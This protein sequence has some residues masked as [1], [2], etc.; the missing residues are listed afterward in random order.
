MHSVM[1]AKNAAKTMSESR[2]E[3]KKGGRKSRRSSSKRGVSHEGSSRSVS[4]EGS[5]RSVPREGSSRSVSR[6]GSSR[7]LSRKSSSRQLAR[8][9][10][11][12]ELKQAV[13]PEEA[14]QLLALLKQEAMKGGPEALVGWVI[15]TP[16][17]GEQE[18]PD[19]AEG[20]VVAIERSLGSSTRHMVRFLSG[21]CEV[22]SLNRAKRRSIVGN[23]HAGHGHKV[24]FELLRQAEH[25]PVCSGVLLKLGRSGVRRWNKRHFELNPL[26]GRLCYHVPGAQGKG[27]PP[28]GFLDL[29]REGSHAEVWNFAQEGKEPPDPAQLF[30][31]AV[32]CG[33]RQMVI[34]AST[35]SEMAKWMA[36]LRDSIDYW[37]GP[38]SLVRKTTAAALARKL[39]LAESVRLESTH[40]AIDELVQ[41]GSTQASLLLDVEHAVASIPGHA[42]PL[43]AEDEGTLIVLEENMLEV[44]ELLR[45]DS[46]DLYDHIWDLVEALEAGKQDL[47][48]MVRACRLGEGGGVSARACR[49]RFP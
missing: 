27:A 18:G 29:G 40:A 19:R 39:E 34:A 6:E 31:F 28:R 26:C 32:V 16:K 4:R 48:D 5:S 42:R 13:S 46:V 35:Q 7:G 49:S 24:D 3:G 41:M 38:K 8:Q 30:S 37:C 23:L 22:L 20:V 12:R 44:S 11:R 43:A 36:A 10:S 25:G 21:D 9:E 47:A 33:K 15:A 1:S 17:L 14:L 2:S 45:A